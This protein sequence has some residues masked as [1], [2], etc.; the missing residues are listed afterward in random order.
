[1]SEFPGLEKWYLQR[2]PTLSTHDVEL[3]QMLP[4]HSERTQTPAVL[5]V[6]L[7]NGHVRDVPVRDRAVTA[8]EVISTICESGIH[9]PPREETQLCINGAPVAPFR[10]VIECFDGTAGTEQPK[11]LINDDGS[12]KA[13]IIIALCPRVAQGVRDL[14]PWRRLRD[15]D[16]AAD[17]AHCAQIGL[18]LKAGRPVPQRPEVL[19]PEEA[20][21][22]AHF[23]RDSADPEPHSSKERFEM[24]MK[25]R[26]SATCRGRNQNKLRPLRSARWKESFPSKIPLTYR[27]HE[28]NWVEDADKLSA[29]PSTIDALYK[30]FVM[31]AKERRQ[32]SRGG[33]RP[34]AERA[35]RPQSRGST[36][37]D[38]LNARDEA[39]D[40]RSPGA[41]EAMDELHG[42]HRRATL[43]V[44]FKPS[45]SSS[46]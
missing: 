11:H 26:R 40:P 27:W 34:E 5:R 9:N 29:D 39:A 44:D 12:L 4:P 19:K 38:L 7:W 21:P 10:P 14:P 15:A 35:Q 23:E 46:R 1:M 24:F 42:R 17:A 33:A 13:S 16:R 3:W 2:K 25:R 28:K 45:E 36:A 31:S 22:P 18:A 8:S 32:R 43:P 20:T 6:M 30:P 41:R 37:Q